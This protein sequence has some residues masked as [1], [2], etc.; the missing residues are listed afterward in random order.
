MPIAVRHALRFVPAAVLSAIICPA[1]L[2]RHGS[3]DLSPENLRL[4]AAL[5]AAL[6]AWR[7]R[8]MS[9]TIA[10][11]MVVLWALIFLAG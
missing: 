7:T 8:S 1:V 5:V 2:V 9:C 3:V 10:T 11:G 6:V 4:V